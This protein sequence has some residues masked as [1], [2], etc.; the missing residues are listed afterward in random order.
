MLSSVSTAEADTT[1]FQLSHGVLSVKIPY[2]HS[3][4]TFAT[5][6]KKA[7]KETARL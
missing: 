3:K 4:R 6:I 2:T 7:K 5:R 1:E